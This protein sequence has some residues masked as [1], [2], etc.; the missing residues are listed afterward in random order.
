MTIVE[1]SATLLG[2]LYVVLE[3]K[4]N[5]YMWPIGGASALLYTLLFLNS[6]LYGSAAMQVWYIGASF[7]GWFKWGGEGAEEV[8]Y[9]VPLKRA[10]VSGAAALLLFMITKWLLAISGDPLPLTDSL[11]FALSLLATYWVANKYI[12]HWYIWIVVNIIGLFLYGSQ[13]LYFTAA[14][15]L[16]YVVASIVGLLEW[17]KFKGSLREA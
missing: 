9:R 1:I 15:Y 3:I 7:Y 16:F 2:L 12:E 13:E 5:R 17:R 6:S 14:L 10:L 11:F 4:Q 8:A